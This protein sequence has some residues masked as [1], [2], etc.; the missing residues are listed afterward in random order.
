M[1]VTFWGKD[2][3]LIVKW[4]HLSYLFLSPACARVLDVSSYILVS[5]QR[6]YFIHVC[7]TLNIVHSRGKRKPH[8][9]SETMYFLA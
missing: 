9:F 3:F 5:E 7:D 8:H 4:E 1:M 6:V 2:G